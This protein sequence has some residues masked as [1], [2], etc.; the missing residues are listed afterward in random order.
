M[1]INC[2]SHAHEMPFRSNIGPILL[3]SL[4]VNGSSF[5]QLPFN[6]ETKEGRRKEEGIMNRRTD[7]QGMM[8]CK[9]CPYCSK[10]GHLQHLGIIRLKG[11][12]MGS[13]IPEIRKTKNVSLTEILLL[14]FTTNFLLRRVSRQGTLRLIAGNKLR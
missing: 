1:P 8:K 3:R 6:G 2:P 14:S 5:L 10:E 4:P 11:L 13:P 7:E 9:Q 12:C